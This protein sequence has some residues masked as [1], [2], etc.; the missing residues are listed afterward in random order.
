M[1]FV[2]LEE[3]NLNEEKVKENDG[4]GGSQ[5]AGESVQMK[6]SPGVCPESSPVSVPEPI[7]DIENQQVPPG[8]SY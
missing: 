5:L 8:G 7:P 6:D 3:D 1:Y 2:A 4:E